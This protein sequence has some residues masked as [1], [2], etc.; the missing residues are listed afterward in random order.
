MDG[1]AFHCK[2]SISDVYVKGEGEEEKIYVKVKRE[3]FAGR[4]PG[5]FRSPEVKDGPNRRVYVVEGRVLVFMRD[6]NPDKDAM[7]SPSRVVT[8]KGKPDFSHTIIPTRDLLF[9]FSALTFNAH[10]IHL[11]KAYC[12]EVE[13]HRNLLV[14]GNLMVVLVIEV[15]QSYLRT[16]A[17][18]GS[19]SKGLSKEPE[20]IL[21]LQYQ[22]LRP[23][24][25]DEGMKICVR[26]IESSNSE[27]ITRWEVWIEAADGGFSFRGRA[28]TYNASSIASRRAE[29]DLGNVHQE[30]G[31]VEETIPDEETI[32]NEHVALQNEA[33][34][35]VE[36][37]LSDDAPAENKTD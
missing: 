17:W 7:N 12:R 11:D 5:E 26:R 28:N 36:T 10:T 34:A 30:S 15:L 9:R 18:L 4:Y 2:E 1:H 19:S 27:G 32:P 35:R 23:L 8:P 3:I 25:V 24:Y 14:Q 37:Y 6:H 21:G 20:R 29:D 16:R 31:L 22:N 13:G 33:N